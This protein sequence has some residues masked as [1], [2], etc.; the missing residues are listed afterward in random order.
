MK[1]N[2]GIQAS[3]YDSGSQSA[4]GSSGSVVIASIVGLNDSGQPLVSWTSSRSKPEE[5]MTTV[6]I[7]SNMIGRQVAILFNNG[8]QT[9]PVIVGIIQNPLLDLLDA[10]PEHSNNTNNE[11]Q[12]DTEPGNSQHEIYSDG[13]KVLIEASEEIV[14]KCGSSSITLSKSG[15]I[16]IRGKYLMNRSSG[17]NRILGGSVQIN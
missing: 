1:N 14:L 16:I 4:D 3:E 12:L 7:H 6:P 15:K 10:Q 11:S 5:A 8:D 13:K 2:L 17:V 9:K